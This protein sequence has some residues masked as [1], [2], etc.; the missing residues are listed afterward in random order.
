MQFSVYQDSLI[1]GRRSNQDRMGYRYTRDA[2]L[3]VLAD[4]MGGHMR[5]DMAATIALQVMASQFALQ[6]KPYLKNPAQFLRE[7]FLAVHH[8]IHRYRALQNLP[9]TPRTT[10]VACLI[11][12][13]QAIWAHCG[14]SRLYWVRNGDIVAR[15]RDHSHLEHLIAEGKVDLAES[16]NWR[17]RHTLFSCLGAPALPEIAIAEAVSLKPDDML[18][19]CSDGLWSVL[20]D[21]QLIDGL[22]HGTLEQAVSALLRNATT[23]AGEASDNCTALALRWIGDDIASE[24]DDAPPT[25]LID[26]F[27]A[28]VAARFQ[29]GDAQPAGAASGAL[30]GAL[31]GA[32]AAKAATAD[33]LVPPALPDK[34][35]ESS[36]E[37]AF[38]AEFGVALSATI[39]ASPA[40][41]PMPPSETEI[42]QA[43]AQLRETIVHS[44]RTDR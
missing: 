23:L 31:S 35:A 30:S 41:A 14:D 27:A 39:A 20:P 36:F 22:L 7:G 38:A 6:A 29:A 19:L 4:G 1:G 12:H 11:Q 26:D 40:A 13:G 9:E 24:S 43:V 34:T 21:T 16:D 5:G 17:D 33:T 15:T 42:D 28:S 2:L 8:E 10:L 37:A 25:L 18:L 44:S 32:A 3:L